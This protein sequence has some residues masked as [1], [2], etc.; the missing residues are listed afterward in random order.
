MAQTDGHRRT[1]PTRLIAG[2]ALVL[3][4]A[5][6]AA[7]SSDAA[8][9]AAIEQLAVGTWACAPDRAGDP[10]SPFHIQIR[11]GGFTVTLDDTTETNHKLTGTWSV[12]GGDL[13]IGFTG[14]AAGA[15]DMGI[16]AFD[17]LTPESTGFRLTEPGI[18]A[19]S[20]VTEGMTVEELEAA[21][22]EPPVLDVDT[23]MRGTR[24]ITLDAADSDPW[25]CDR[26]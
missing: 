2:A 15:P 1:H 23:E 19:P 21:L 20:Q 24:S 9:E 10:G 14:K 3:A 13:E 26:Q 18:F 16:A 7:C 17:E 12:E 8:K 25:T 11:K 4:A 22:E 6:F 5:T